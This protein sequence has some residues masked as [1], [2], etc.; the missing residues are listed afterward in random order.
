MVAGGCPSSVAEC[1][2]LKPEAL[3]SIPGGA[4]FLS[5]P[6][7]FQ[8]SLDSNGPDYLWLDDLHWSSDC[9]GVPSIA[10]PVLWLH[11]PS[12]HDQLLFFLIYS[13]NLIMQYAGYPFTCT[14]MHTAG[15]SVNVVKCMSLPPCLVLVLPTIECTT[16]LEAWII[17]VPIVIGLLLLG[18]FI[19]V[20][21]KLILVLLVSPLCLISTECLVQ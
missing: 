6:L 8:R 12:F 18:V 20:A 13:C 7:P 10:L 15:V 11:S 1:W 3:G 17:A 19:L 9:G 16:P 5:Y 21:I 2:R 14:G 4:T